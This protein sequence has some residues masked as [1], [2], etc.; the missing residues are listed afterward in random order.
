MDQQCARNS[1]ACDHDPTGRRALAVIRGIAI[2]GVLSGLLAGTSSWARAQLPTDRSTTAYLEAL[3]E[4]QLFGSIVRH[5]ELKFAESEVSNGLKSQLAARWIRSLTL[6]TLN[7]EPVAAASVWPEVRNTAT[8]LVAETQFFPQHVLVRFQASLIGLGE[9]RLASLYPAA[10]GA[11]T[12]LR[13]KGIE[14]ARQAFHDL[15]ILHQE[16]IQRAP[17]IPEQPTGQDPDLSREQW[18]ALA[19][20]VEYQMLAALSVRARFIADSDTASRIDT[21]QQVLELAGK[22]QP[23]VSNESVLWWETQHLTFEALRG[24]KDWKNWDAKWQNSPLA[25]APEQVLGKMTSARIDALLDQANY[26]EALAQANDFFVLLQKRDGPSLR[27]VK[28][29]ADLTRVTAWPEF[30]LARARLYLMLAIEADRLASEKSGERVDVA[31]LGAESEILEFSR[32][33][34]KQHGSF[35][36]SELNR[37]LLSGSG[38]NAADQA[39]PVSVLLI[40]QSIADGN[41]AEVQNL[42]QNGVQQAIRSGNDPLAFDL[43]NLVAGIPTLVPPQPWMVEQIEA[44]A[45]GFPKHAKATATH[46][47]ANIIA[48]KLAE[49]LPDYR[50]TA[51][52]VW[53]RHIAE[54]PTAESANK[55]RLQLAAVHVKEKQYD[56]A[57]NVLL[58]V[59]LDSPSFAM[60]TK[61]LGGLVSSL[62]LDNQQTASQRAQTAE[63]WVKAIRPQLQEDGQWLR[64]WTLDSKRMALI[65]LQFQLEASD[66]Q[67]AWTNTLLKIIEQQAPE[68]DAGLRSRWA[69]VAALMEYHQVSGGTQALEELTA[70]GS[71]PVAADLLWLAQALELRLPKLGLAGEIEL[72]G[73]NATR[74]GMIRRA[75]ALQIAVGDLLKTQHAEV[76]ESYNAWLIQQR[77]TALLYSD[78]IADA[79][80]EARKT[81]ADHEQS[82]PHQ[83][84]LGYSL[85]RSNHP[86]DSTAAEKQWRKIGFLTQKNSEPWFE[87]KYFLAE[88]QRRLGKK[89]EAARVLQFV[90][91]TESQAWQ[92]SPYREQLERLLKSIAANP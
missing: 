4:R 80:E 85:A 71:Q 57:A 78:R 63:Q 50:T 26:P 39:A 40:R 12:E 34:G 47:F 54:W 5:C 70:V 33:V 89:T 43:A 87:S 53:S 21:S 45:L 52:A 14:A 28:N 10:P 16:I 6:Q 25:L 42:V 68:L 81:A 23:K 20:D 91:E 19:R 88:S 44:V 74:N 35:W 11:G 18:Y 36:S 51:Q 2:V 73:S 9:A 24:L 49:A 56:L 82:L 3:E 55:V 72:A 37:R 15:R 8:R 66:P 90:K 84:W 58:E 92:Q 22:L 38:S 76:F 69:V 60:S 7:L 62:V 31:R 30:D 75:A 32:Y 46:H 59:P 77:I 61:Q 29:T 48:G 1:L 17:G 13:E 41:W 65:L 64:Q 67:A 86:A 83:Q 27:E 79:I